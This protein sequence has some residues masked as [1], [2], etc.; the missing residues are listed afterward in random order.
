MKTKPRL[1]RKIHFAFGSVILALLVV[2]A[3]SYHNIVGSSESN[4]WVRHSHEVLE[5]LQDLLFAMESVESS[6]SGFV[7]TGKE[8]YL[9]TYHANRLRV[10]HDLVTVRSQTVDNPEQQ[11]RLSTVESLAAQKIQRLEAVMRLRPT[12]S[13]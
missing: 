8:A 9:E 13:M 11:R 4:R 7:L 10:E 2:A 1:N 12:R 3:I 5:N 6:S